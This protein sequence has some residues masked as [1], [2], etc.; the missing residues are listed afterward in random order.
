M[1]MENLIKTLQN[2]REEETFTD[3]M[4]GKYISH[5]FDLYT[6][7]TQQMNNLHVLG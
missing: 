5:G 1:N 4:Q 6:H 3:I 2:T 7:Y